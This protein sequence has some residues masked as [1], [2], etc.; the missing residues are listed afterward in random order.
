M[1]NILQKRKK[2]YFSKIPAGVSGLGLGIGG[3]GNAISAQLNSQFIAKQFSLSEIQI[4]QLKIASVSIQAIFI[5]ITTICFLLILGKILWHF[6]IFKKELRDPLISSY[7]PTEMMCLASI[8]YF[9]GVVSTWND[10]KNV[11]INAGTIIAN[12]LILI[13]I[14]GHFILLTFFIIHVIATHSFKVDAAYSSWLVPTCGI[15][16]SCGFYSR[17]GFLLPNELFQVTW[18]FAFVNLLILFPYLIY[19]HIFF[20]MIEKGKIPSIAIFFAA[21]NLLLNGLLTTHIYPSYYSDAFI[22]VFALILFLFSICGMMF[23]YS[24]LYKCSKINFNPGFAAFTFPASISSLATIK[25]ADYIYKALYAND[26]SNVFQANQLTLMLS[27]IYYVIAFI[28][29]WF[30]VSGTIINLT[31]LCQYSCFMTKYTKEFSKE[32]KSFKLQKID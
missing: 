21:P 16:L 31:I 26:P 19:K 11:V 6:G 2:D 28:G 5:L 4:E 18:Y 13:S 3:L 10:D 30:L 8:S 22:F 9:I 32:Y 27:G 23:Y 14:I 15:A 25:F 1:E 7:L 20:K 12:I 29:F 24:T 17:L